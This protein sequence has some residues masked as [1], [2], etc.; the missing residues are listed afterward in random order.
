MLGKGLDSNTPS[1][2]PQ[3]SYRAAEQPLELGNTKQPRTFECFP[4]SCCWLLPY[5]TG[6]GDV[7]MRCLMNAAGGRYWGDMTS[8][9]PESWTWA[10]RGFLALPCPWKALSAYCSTVGASSRMQPWESTVLLRP[11]GQCK[12]LNQVKPLYKLLRTWQTG[13][14]ISL[15]SYPRQAF[16][17]QVS[18]QFKPATYQR[19][20]SCL[21]LLSLSVPGI[22]SSFRFHPWDSWACDDPI[23]VLN[24]II[25]SRNKQEVNNKAGALKS[26]L[27]PCQYGSRGRSGDQVTLDP[28]PQCPNCIPFGEKTFLP[29][30]MQLFLMPPCD[31]HT[32]LSPK[33]PMPLVQ[34]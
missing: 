34:V 13:S 25:S 26:F 10:L 19:G 15:R 33:D 11:S 24:E 4:W 21:F 29:F 7:N 32:L 31:P 30:Q 6:K 5:S 2:Q 23:N 18:L 20:V 28:L 22:G 17:I 27:F 9:W 12:R 1:T 3:R 8:S 16:Y 14:E